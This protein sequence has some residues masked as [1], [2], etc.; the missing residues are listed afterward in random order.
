MVD[1]RIRRPPESNGV[2]GR[3][4]ANY[5]RHFGGLR[6]L[7]SRCWQASCWHNGARHAASHTFATKT[8]AQAWLSSIETDIK[9]GVWLDPEG[10]KITVGSLLQHWLATVVDGRVGSDNTRSNYAQIVRV[11]IAPALGELKL[12]ELSAERV[13]QFLA[14][15][16]QAGLARTH[17]SRMR[18]ILADALRHAERPFAMVKGA[19]SWPATQ[20]PWR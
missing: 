14:A 1:R 5:R 2:D 15:K 16:A 8:D 10:S 3:T 6:R 7:P 12:N 13:D 4:P 9:R 20:P 18:S 19:A 11:H 17:V